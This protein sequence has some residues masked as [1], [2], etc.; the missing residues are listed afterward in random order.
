MYHWVL[1]NP[2][3]LN[4][5]LSCRMM[6]SR[7]SLACSP[8][9][10]YSTIQVL[11]QIMVFTTW[12]GLGVQPMI[13][14]SISG[15]GDSSGCR[16]TWSRHQLDIQEPTTRKFVLWMSYQQVT[17]RKCDFE[18]EMEWGDVGWDSGSDLFF[19]ISKKNFIK[20]NSPNILGVYIE[21]PR[22]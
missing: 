13:D 17:P 4:Q 5:S 22:I 1:G 14:F 15:M 11:R 20:K 21:L 12:I 10:R 3:I 18:A 16:W 19:L 9:L 2:L 8:W 7:L 6:K